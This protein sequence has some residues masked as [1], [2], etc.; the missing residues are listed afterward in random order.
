VPAP[1][2][3]GVLVDVAREPEPS[4]G[5]PPPVLAPRRRVRRRRSGARRPTR[6]SSPRARSRNSSRART[7]SPSSSYSS[8]SLPLALP[9]GRLGKSSPRVRASGRSGA[10]SWSP[11]TR[12]EVRARFVTE[13]VWRSEPGDVLPR[14]RDARRQR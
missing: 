3:D 13:A 11:P 1:R 8:S 7:N 10:P 12:F 9:E 14:P 4:V 5:G 6:G 2:G